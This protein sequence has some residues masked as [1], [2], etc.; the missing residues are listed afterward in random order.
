MQDL[1]ISYPVLQV[2]EICYDNI[3]LQ[4]YWYKVSK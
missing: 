3:S 2:K 4:Y 1:I